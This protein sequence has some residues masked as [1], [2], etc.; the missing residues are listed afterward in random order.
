MKDITGELF[1]L[2]VSLSNFRSRLETG[3]TKFVLNVI[4]PQW[5]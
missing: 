5:I 3:Y 4:H 2:R 1:K